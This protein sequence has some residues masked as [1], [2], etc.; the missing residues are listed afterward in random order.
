MRTRNI[1]ETDLEY[2]RGLLGA[3]NL[4]SVV[5]LLAEEDQVV[6]VGD[7]AGTRIVSQADNVW[8]AIDDVTTIAKISDQEIADQFGDQLVQLSDANLK[9]KLASIASLQENLR[10]HPGVL[11][12]RSTPAAIVVVMSEVAVYDGPWEWEGYRVYA[13]VEM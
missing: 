11:D 1:P 12:V 8:E 7:M 10:S 9:N 5:F 6:A 13:E 3:S 2:Y 4:I